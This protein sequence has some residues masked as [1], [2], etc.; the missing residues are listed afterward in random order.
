MKKE[1]CIICSNAKGKRVCRTNNNSLICP[2]CCAKIRTSNC[3]DCIHYT[4]AEKYAKEKS[5]KQESEEFM[6]VIDS[7]ISEKVDQALAM[8][9]KGDVQSGE[10]IIFALLDGHSHIDMV[11]YGMGVVCAMKEQYG[12]AIAYFD[13]TIKIN[14][15]FAEAWFNKGAAHQK[16]LELGDTIRAFQRVIEFGDSSERFVIDAKHFI[17]DW[18]KR[19]RKSSGLSLNGY[20]ES[21]D[22]FNDAYAAMESMEW[23]KAL[24]GFR[25]VLSMDPQHI[26][27]Y[28]NIGICYG[29]LGKKQEALAAL[30]KAL[31]LDPEYEPAMTNLKLVSSLAD[32]EKPLFAK[33][34]SVEYYKD[35]LQRRNR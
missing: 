1:K 24:S 6:M 20:L 29:Q 13:R 28:G 34:E 33:F 14:P 2:V 8:V 26:Q 10:D 18:E 17:A 16:R 31:E 5:L 23:E 11:Q 25:K 7:E 27:S 15:Y 12:E 22:M 30:E 35:S 3:D 4:Q 32:G 9:E 19:I 21:I